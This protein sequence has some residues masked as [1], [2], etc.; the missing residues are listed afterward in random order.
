MKVLMMTTMMIKMKM[1]IVKNGVIEG[2][3]DCE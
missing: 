1:M 3:Y 2:D